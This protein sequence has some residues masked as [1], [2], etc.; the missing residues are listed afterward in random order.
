M[1]GTLRYIETL[2]GLT[3]FGLAYTPAYAGSLRVCAASERMVRSILYVD[4]GAHRRQ[5]PPV[6]AYVEGVPLPR[7]INVDVRV[8]ETGHSTCHVSSPGLDALDA[9]HRRRLLEQASAWAYAPFMRDGVAVP[10]V[11]QEQ[12]RPVELPARHRSLPKVPLKAVKLTLARRGCLNGCPDY[13]VEMRG[14]G[15]VTYV[16]NSGVDVAGRHT[17]RVDPSEVAALVRSAKNKNLWSLKREYGIGIPDAQSYQITME[18]GGHIHA[19]DESNGNLAGMPESVT[20]FENEI[21]RRSGAVGWI[22]LSAKT[23]DRLQATGLRLDSAEAGKLL[24][25]VVDHADTVDDTPAR[26]LI[27]GGAP[28]VGDR[29]AVGPCLCNGDGVLRRALLNRR[30]SLVPALL[31]RGS[32]R[33]EGKLDQSKLDAAFRDAIMGGD[34]SLVEAI[35]NAGGA[36]RRP[37]LTF[38]ADASDVDGSARALPISLLLVGRYF[39]PPADWGGFAIARW[40]VEHGVDLKGRAGDGDT[41]LH[42]AA[43]AGDVAFVRYLLAQGIDVNSP[44]NEFSPPIYATHDEDV[45][46]VLLNAG[47]NTSLYVRSGY[48]LR[49]FAMNARWWRVLAWLDSHPKYPG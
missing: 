25:R 4:V 35:W 11:V 24:Y 3:L 39:E 44:G 38:T 30:A 34:F 5:N 26:R 2:L 22:R 42:V 7:A 18:M 9:E 15:R 46:L 48:S 20:A 49:V 10:V 17:W 43:R 16:G 23:L 45:A 27:A 12:V 13:T 21:D 37:A 14:D 31:A 40:L 1:H 32:L 28:I 47:A 29:G 19:I 33:V 36:G 6:I 41:L 8:D